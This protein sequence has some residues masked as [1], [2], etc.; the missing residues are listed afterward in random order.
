MTSSL[1]PKIV[2]GR[3]VPEVF[4]ALSSWEGGTDHV[5]QPAPTQCT[6][7]W[8]LDA[9]YSWDEKTMHAPLLIGFQI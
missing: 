7:H 3:R 8:K 1:D 9:G 5:T 2:V 4:V 6:I